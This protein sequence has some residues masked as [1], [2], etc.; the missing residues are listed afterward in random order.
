MKKIKIAVLGAGDRGF[1]YGEYALNHPHEVDHSTHIMSEP[2][3][4]KNQKNK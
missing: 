4:I 2:I 1:D 3:S